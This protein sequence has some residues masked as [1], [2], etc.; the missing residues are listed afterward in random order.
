MVTFLIFQ[1]KM[2]CGQG[3][4]H[5]VTLIIWWW[6]PL[7]AA[8]VFFPSFISLNLHSI[9][10]V[11][12]LPSQQYTLSRVPL[13]FLPQALLLINLMT[14]CFVGLL[15]GFL[16]TLWIIFP[17]QGH[18]LSVLHSHCTLLWLQDPPDLVPVPSVSQPKLT[19]ERKSN[20]S[21]KRKN[22]KM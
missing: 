3:V 12:L 19:E 18:D 2:L 21:S 15:L 16:A 6:L 5:C 8:V 22:Q 13:V 17:T 10:K 20:N 4:G 14:F 11:P 1:T 7:T 9:G